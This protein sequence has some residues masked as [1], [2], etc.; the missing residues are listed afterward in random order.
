MFSNERARDNSPIFGQNKILGKRSFK[1]FGEKQFEKQIKSPSSK[2][3]HGES[4][5]VSMCL[6]K[7]IKQ[8][9]NEE[10]AEQESE[11]SDVSSFAAS[12]DS[13]EE[14]QPMPEN[15]H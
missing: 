1:L 6:N 3:S 11:I 5:L 15:M 9:P 8:D 12:D 2:I 10:I 14:F 13:E 7:Y 4:S